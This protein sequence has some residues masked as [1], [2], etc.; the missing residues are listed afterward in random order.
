MLDNSI[1]GDDIDEST[2]SGVGIGGVETF[3]GHSDDDSESPKTAFAHCPAGKTIL[4]TGYRVDG[5]GARA[6]SEGNVTSNVDVHS[7]TQYDLPHSSTSGGYVAV[8]AFEDEPTNNSWEIVAF[9]RCANA[10]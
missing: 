3:T 9:A 5:A 1:T 8:T 6:G 2:L 10:E 4:S 7:V